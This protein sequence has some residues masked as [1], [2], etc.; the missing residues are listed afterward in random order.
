MKATL[1]FLT[2][3][4]VG[5]WVAE[6]RYVVQTRAVAVE[7]LED[8]GDESKAP[9]VEARKGIFIVKVFENLVKS[10]FEC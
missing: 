9:M 5:L 2:V 6:A 3:L 7:L 8:K 1:V 10:E 4:L